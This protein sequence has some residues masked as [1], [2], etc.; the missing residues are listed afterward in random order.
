MSLPLSDRPGFLRQAIPHDAPSL[1]FTLRCFTI[2]DLSERPSCI[3]VH[4]TQCL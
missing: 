4:V 3:L 2:C 1:T